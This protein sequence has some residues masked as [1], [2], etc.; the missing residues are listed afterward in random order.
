MGEEGVRTEIRNTEAAI[1][2]RVE[3]A[4]QKSQRIGVGKLL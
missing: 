4:N 3:S 2:E 1:R